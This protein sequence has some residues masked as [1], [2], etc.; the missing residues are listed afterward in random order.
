VVWFIGM[1]KNELIQFVL[2]FW[3]NQVRSITGG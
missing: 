2:L 1:I 3:Y